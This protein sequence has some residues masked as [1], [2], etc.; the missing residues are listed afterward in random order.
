MAILELTHSGRHS[1]LRPVIA[2]HDEI[3]D[4]ASGV[5]EDYPLITDGELE[6]LEDRYVDAARL[7]AQAGFDGIDVKACH[8]YLA[9]E[10]LGA[11]QRE[12]KYGGSFENRTRFLINV[13][14][15]IRDRLGPGT[16]ITTRLSAYEG[17]PGGWGMQPGPVLRENLEEPIRLVKMLYERGVRVVNISA[18]NPYISPHIGRPFDRPM[19]GGA[20]P[21]EHPLEGVA[22]LVGLVRQVQQSLPEMVVIGTGYSW[23][24]QYLGNSAAAAI[25]RGWVSVVGLGREALAYP[26]F[27]R[28][29]LTAGRLDPRKTC[30]T[31]SLCSQLMREGGPTGCVIFDC[32]LYRP[33]YRQ[34]CSPAR[35]PGDPA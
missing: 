28:D 12:G 34:K 9:A 19:T 3:L 8:G 18:G 7:A 24:R 15:K 2:I 23:L 32:E 35:R 30:V 29:L 11:R 20:F 6:D 26:D 22:R 16:A 25:R 13:V 27:A 14:D 5:P 4:R 10:L 21:E 33:V 1:T 31:C 17:I